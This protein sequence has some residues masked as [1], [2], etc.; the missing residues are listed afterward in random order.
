MSQSV[1]TFQDITSIN[2]LN[3]KFHKTPPPVDDEGRKFYKH[4]GGK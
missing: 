3:A 4:K 1:Q 2:K